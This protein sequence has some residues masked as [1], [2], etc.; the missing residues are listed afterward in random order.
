MTTR[1]REV[2]RES[3]ETQARILGLR[4]VGVD[5]DAL[6]SRVRAAAQDIDRLDDLRPQEHEPAVRFAASPERER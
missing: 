4:L 5:T 2:S 6:A 1:P 3:I